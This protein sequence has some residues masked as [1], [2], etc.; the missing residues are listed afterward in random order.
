MKAGPSPRLLQLLRVGS[1]TVP[2]HRQ[3]SSSGVKWVC[4]VV[5]VISSVFAGNVAQSQA[6][7]A[8]MLVG[9]TIFLAARKECPHEWQRET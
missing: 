8:E 9:V 5:S 2:R 7:V 1:L 3:I 6:I 4:V